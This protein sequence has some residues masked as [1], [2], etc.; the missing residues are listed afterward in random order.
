MRV[1]QFQSLIP[2]PHFIG[3]VLS[4]NEK[5]TDNTT[6]TTSSYSFKEKPPVMGVFL[7]GIWYLK[8]DIVMRNSE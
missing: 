1:F 6:D 8:F 7:L 3:D 4:R 5:E 2:V